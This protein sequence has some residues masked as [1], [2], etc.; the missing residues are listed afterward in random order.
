[1][2]SPSH[3]IIAVSIFNNLIFIIEEFALVLSNIAVAV[4]AFVE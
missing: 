4:V 1:V 3:I 2:S